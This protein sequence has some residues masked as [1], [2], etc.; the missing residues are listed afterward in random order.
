MAKGADYRKMIN[1]VRWRELR[2]RRLEAYPMCEFCN[3]QDLLTAACEVHHVV[4][5]E[6]G[7]SPAERERLM[8]SYGNL[9]ALC[10][11]CHVEAHIQMGRSGKKISKERNEQRT[12]AAIARLFGGERPPGGV[13]LIRGYP[14]ETSPPSFVK[15]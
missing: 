3:E 10:H 5:V 1:S 2:R 11:R 8:F 4:P 13:F 14:F 12:A 6:S 9:R 7:V 15:V